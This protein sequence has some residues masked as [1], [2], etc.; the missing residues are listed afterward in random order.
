MA[1]TPTV[2]S[3]PAVHYPRELPYVVFI[4]NMRAIPPVQDVASKMPKGLQDALRAMP[5]N[6]VS[7]GGRVS[8]CQCRAGAVGWLRALPAVVPRGE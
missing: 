2:S 1:S 6:D 3:V 5:G 8:E 4:I 7:W